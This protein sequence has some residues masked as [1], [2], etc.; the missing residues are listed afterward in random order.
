MKREKIRVDQI[1]VF[2]LIHKVREGLFKKTRTHTR[3]MRLLPFLLL[4]PS[5]ALLL[6]DLYRLSLRSCLRSADLPLTLIFCMRLFTWVPSAPEE[7]RQTATDRAPAHFHAKPDSRS[8][9]HP[10]DLRRRRN[11]DVSETSRLNKLKNEFISEP[12]FRSD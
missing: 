1:C 11:G 8:E 4:L 10:E 5:W 7:T 12:R 3:R 6:F 2:A 9:N